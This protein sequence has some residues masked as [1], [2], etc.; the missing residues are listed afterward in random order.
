MLFKK[1]AFKKDILL[2]IIF[3]IIAGSVALTL[4]IFLNNPWSIS[5]PVESVF[6]IKRPQLD[7][8]S[9]PGER[10][11]SY[12]IY[13]DRPKIPQILQIDFN[14]LDVQKGE[15]QVIAVKVYDKGDTITSIN[16]VTAQI[17]G[18]NNIEP[19]LLKMKYVGE[20]DLTTIWKGSWIAGDI[21]KIHSAVVTAISE[22]G[23]SFVEISFPE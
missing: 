9:P 19:V 6:S 18:D 16:A 7:E 20:P 2:L 14:P 4:T 23:E 11:E 3:L 17:V 21:G 15:E 22:N 12:L 1:I 10:K 8:I 13:S 5:Q